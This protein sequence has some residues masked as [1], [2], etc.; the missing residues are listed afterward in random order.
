MLNDSGHRR[1][2]KT[3]AVRDMAQGKGRCDLMP[4]CS[5]IRLSKHYE[6]GAIKY[7]ERNWEKGIPISSYLD[8]AF[9]HLF[10]YMDGMDDE[11]HLAAAAFNVL[12]A[13]WTEEKMPELQNIQTRRKE[14]E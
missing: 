5:L 4:A 1:E 12:C 9:R 2:F 7:G 13:M 8:S 11:D 14:N 3:G 10:K 6:A